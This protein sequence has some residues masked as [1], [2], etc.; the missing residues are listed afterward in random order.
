[1][2]RATRQ[3]KNRVKAKA[4]AKPEDIPEPSIGY[5]HSQT[6]GWASTERASQRRYE[7]G[8]NSWDHRV[9]IIMG[10]TPNHGSA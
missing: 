10:F 4:K 7:H 9:P 2:L 3:L 1:M 8:D 5:R 6:D